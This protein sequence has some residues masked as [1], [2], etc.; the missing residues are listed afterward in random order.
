MRHLSHIAATASAV[1]A[2]NITAQVRSITA[3]ARSITV[4]VLTVA[5]LAAATLSLTACSSEKSEP[6]PEVVVVTDDP[7][8]V[9]STPKYADD[10][11]LLTLATPMVFETGTEQISYNEIELCES[12]DYVIRA[13]ILPLSV[14]KR[15]KS[16]RADSD[17]DFEPVTDFFTGTYTRT[18][19]NTYKLNELNATLHI[20]AAGGKHRTVTLSSLIGT[21][22][23][24]AEATQ[25]TATTARTN[26]LCRTWTTTRTSVSM[27]VGGADKIKDVTYTGTF[28]LGLLTSHIS[29][30]A[31]IDFYYDSTWSVEDVIF[32]K[33]GNVYFSFSNGSIFAGTWSWTDEA[34]G[35]FKLTWE[36]ISDVK[37]PVFDGQNTAIFPD[38][39][40]CQLSFRNTFTTKDRKSCEVETRIT[41]KP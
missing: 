28:N 8:V 4:G 24:E 1:A 39:Q 20:D 7:N 11:V 12:G 34:A 9:L 41:M 16:T 29:S 6:A 38:S 15:S 17:A 40:S 10:A 18:S 14:A 23:S 37:I 2:Q 26:N 22:E 31:S 25:G 32:T 19:A 13:S 5:A 35:T 30:H 3:Q 33:T 36:D 27:A 21:F